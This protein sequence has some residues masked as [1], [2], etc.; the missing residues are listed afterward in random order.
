V[1]DP[2]LSL[3][4]GGSLRLGAKEFCETLLLLL[5]LPCGPAAVTEVEVPRAWFSRN[6][7]FTAG[8]IK[9]GKAEA[10]DCAPDPASEKKTENGV[11]PA[12][13]SFGEV[14]GAGALE[15]SFRPVGAPTLA[16]AERALGPA[17]AFAASAGLAGTESGSAG[18]ALWAAI[19]PANGPA[20]SAPGA[21]SSGPAGCTPVSSADPSDWA[22]SSAVTANEFAGTGTGAALAR[23]IGEA[24]AGPVDGLWLAAV[25]NPESLPAGCVSNA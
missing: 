25:G 8:A 4:A 16:L 11:G 10:A 3:A 24:L 21:L 23:R 18:A 20:A 13:N 12:L 9:C 22:R 5:P 17:A 14:D 2:A 7:E 6:A 19:I 15:A 1:P